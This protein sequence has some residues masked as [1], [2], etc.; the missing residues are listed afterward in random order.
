MPTPSS[1]ITHEQI[2]AELHELRG[3]VKARQDSDDTR[4]EEIQRRLGAV[5]RMCGEL[6][7]DVKGTRAT[8][9]TLK[10]AGIAQAIASV[11]LGLIGLFERNPLAVLVFGAVLIVWGAGGVAQVWQAVSP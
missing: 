4:W 2:N 10:P 3:A 11:L 8:V 5:E 1:Q 7:G 6:A 9:E